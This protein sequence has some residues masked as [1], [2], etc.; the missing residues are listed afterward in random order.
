MAESYPDKIDE[1]IRI[2]EDDLI[3]EQ[4]G[5]G[6]KNFM[7]VIPHLEDVH[8]YLLKCVE[9]V[10]SSAKIPGLLISQ[11][12]RA[13]DGYLNRIKNIREYNPL[14]DGSKNFKRYTEI[15]EEIKQYHNLV[16]T[17]KDSENLLTYCNS[18]LVYSKID[19]PETEKKIGRLYKQLESNLEASNEIVKAQRES[20]GDTLISQYSNIYFEQSK[21]HNTSALTYLAVGIFLSVVLISTIFTFH[22]IL[23]LFIDGNPQYVNIS[24]KVLFIS[25]IIYLINFSFRQFSINKHLSVLNKTRQNALKSYKVFIESFDKEDKDVRNSMVIEVARSIFE[26]G[27]TGYVS[28]KS[29]SA[30]AGSII[31]VVKYFGKNAPQ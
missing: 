14:E 10:E 2:T 20:S 7:E 1:L 21:K 27:F 6:E 30:K 12:F 5:K 22:Y 26:Q 25:Y 13:V 24:T 19:L 31:D 15:L 28:S 3:Q 4:V 11:Y 23:P 17:N 16:F 29:D 8:R 18:I 9:V